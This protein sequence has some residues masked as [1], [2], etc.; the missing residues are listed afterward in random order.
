LTD[1]RVASSER[2]SVTVLVAAVIAVILTMVLLSADAARLLAG[3]SRAQTAADAAALAAA[4]EIALSADE[5]P[6]AVAAVY[7]EM[8]G[9]RLVQCVCPDGGPEGP[10]GA[11]VT[12]RVDPGPMFLLSEGADVEAMARAVVEATAP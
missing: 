3:V 1:G 2:G 5:D 7:A 8:N 11:I 10:P 4:Q 6:A 12:V 9:G